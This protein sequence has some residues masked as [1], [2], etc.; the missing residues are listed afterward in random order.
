MKCKFPD[1]PCN[2]RYHSYKGDNSKSW[3]FYCRLREWKKRQKRCPY[4]KSI[5]SKPLEKIVGKMV[6]LAILLLIML[7]LVSCG[8]SSFQDCHSKC[9]D[10]KGD[11]ECS[12]WNGT[13]RDG[14][15]YTGRF[16][17]GYTN[18]SHTMCYDECRGMNND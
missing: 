14:T 10:L 3:G 2:D 9:L 16:C 5:M 4:D 7:S 6:P 8:K 1:K 13:R 15:N 11:S 17:F 12:E 18:D